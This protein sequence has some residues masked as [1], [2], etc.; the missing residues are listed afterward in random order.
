MLD[1]SFACE[2]HC[3]DLAFD[4]VPTPLSTICWWSAVEVVGHELGLDDAKINTSR[5]WLVGEVKL[6]KGVFPLGRWSSSCWAGG[7]TFDL[8]SRG[9]AF[10]VGGAESL[11]GHGRVGPRDFHWLSPHMFLTIRSSSLTAS[12]TTPCCGSLR[13]STFLAPS[14]DA[15]FCIAHSIDVSVEF[16]G[17]DF[18]GFLRGLQSSTI[19][20]L[21]ART[22]E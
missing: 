19:V 7:T 11:T 17:I 14:K 1:W 5:N 15:G 16:D 9:S 22:L 18:K 2:S 3:S 4:P 13:P 20:G 6:Q 12:C 8:F 21:M 10:A